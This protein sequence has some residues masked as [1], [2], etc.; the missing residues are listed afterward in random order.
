VASG[1]WGVTSGL[2]KR[3]A[4]EEHNVGRVKN[5]MLFHVMFAP[6]RHNVGRVKNVMLFHT[7]SAPEGHNIGSRKMN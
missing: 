7:M 4:P 1:K 3:F 2:I 5:V 6:E